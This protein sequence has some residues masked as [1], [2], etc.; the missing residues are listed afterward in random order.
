MAMMAMEYM[1]SSQCLL[2]CG[3]AEWES[4]SGFQ[5]ISIIG[6]LYLT[7]SYETEDGACQH[8]TVQKAFLAIE[9]EYPVLISPL[10]LQ[11]QPKKRT[12]ITSSECWSAARQD[13]GKK[14]SKSPCWCIWGMLGEGPTPM[15]G[16]PR[17]L[18]QDLSR[19][20]VSSAIHL[21]ETPPPSIMA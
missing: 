6:S 15:G 5:I 21:R 10:L 19:E 17:R 12:G 1:L 16:S 11:I 2:L 9:Y 3:I 14:G 18:P 20:T 4:K 8:A 13:K 7:G